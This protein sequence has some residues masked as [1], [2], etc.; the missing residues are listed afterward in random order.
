M[1][2]VTALPLHIAALDEIAPERIALQRVGSTA[3]QTFADESDAEVSAE[4]DAAA[5][6][7][8][9]VEELSPLDDG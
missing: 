1:R 9:E 5:S 2:Y 7:V 4:S 8:S 3:G 6:T